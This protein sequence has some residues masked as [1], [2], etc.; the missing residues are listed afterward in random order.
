MCRD[1]GNRR[2][3]AVDDFSTT[4]SG[5]AAVA[6]SPGKFTLDPCAIAS[7][8][9][10]PLADGEQLVWLFGD[11]DKATVVG[12]PAVQTHV[13]PTFSS[14]QPYFGELLLLGP[15]CSDDASRVCKLEQKAAFNLTN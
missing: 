3:R 9:C 12:V 15:N 10:G 14:P 5:I 13:Y 1:S 4:T 6:G 7:F 11:G 8:A 2:T